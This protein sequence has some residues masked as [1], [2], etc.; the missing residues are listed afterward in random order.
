MRPGAGTRTAA[1]KERERDESGSLRAPAPKNAFGQGP[2]HTAAAMPLQAG[3]STI[4]APG[5]EP[6]AGASHMLQGETCP[7]AQW[8]LVGV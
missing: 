1:K 6:A 8:L 5:N 2:A 4:P 7:P 3:L